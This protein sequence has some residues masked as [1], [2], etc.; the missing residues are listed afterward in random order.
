MNPI[1]SIDVSK[2]N[3][4]AAA[5]LSNSKPF[6]K[7]FKFNHS[8]NDLKNLLSLLDEMENITGT[9]PSIVLEATGNYSKPITSY[10]MS[11]GYDVIVLNPLQ[12][13][14]LKK[15]TIRKVKT[16]PVDTNRIAKVYYLNSFM[17]TKLPDSI[18][19]NLRTACRHYEGFN[20]L[21]TEAILRLRSILDVVF[22]NYDKLFSSV[23]SKI[24]LNFLSNFNTPENVLNANFEELVQ[25]LRVRGRAKS[26]SVE[27]AKLIVET[28]KESLPDN[29]SQ[30][31]NVYALE[32]Y[33]KLLIYIQNI[34]TDVRDQM[35]KWAKR[36]PQYEL[37][38]SIP[39]VGDMTAS[40]I[41]SEI[42][43]ITRFPTEKQIVA[44]AGIDP[45]VYQSGTFRASNN[46]ISKRG[47]TYLRKALYQ[48][49]CAGI[50]RRSSGYANTTLRAYYDK[51][52]AEGKP[53][54]VTIIATCNKLLRIIYAILKSGKTFNLNH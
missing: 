45:S 35:I 6:S 17:P 10:F 34:L 8:P 25:Y 36:S 39:G 54:K 4:Y 48:A 1:L 31:S 23:S 47:S 11:H 41:L 2:S 22:P 27:K 21:Y 18:T 46:K 42:G 14:E 3:S 16:D 38:L 7:P 30:Q 51:K 13:H 49:T 32:Q 33:I 20:I 50:Y 9:E 44:F 28:A 29:T 12:T 53:S 15:K 19:S 5:F 26:W 52:I 24:S 43:D 40:T 37:L